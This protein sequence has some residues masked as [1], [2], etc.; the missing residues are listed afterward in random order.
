M[1]ITKRWALGV[2]GGMGEYINIR[3]CPHPQKK[4]TY[5]HQR[6]MK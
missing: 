4:D 2:L 5:T 6:E 3:I 1:R